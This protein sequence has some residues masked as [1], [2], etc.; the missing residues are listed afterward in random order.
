[1]RSKII[2]AAAMLVLGVSAIASTPALAKGNPHN[3]TGPSCSAADVAARSSYTVNGSGFAASQLLTV[4]VSDAQVMQT[5]SVVSDAGGNF[6]MS[7]YV[8]YAGV[9]TVSVY[10]RSNTPK[11]LASCSFNVT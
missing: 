5:G 4:A 6:S 9:H 10:D 1:M 3:T 2:L 7:A 11:L 8:S